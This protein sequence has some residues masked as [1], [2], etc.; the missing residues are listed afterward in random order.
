MDKIPIRRHVKVKK[1]MRVFNKDDKEYWL[2][3]ENNQLALYG[4]HRQLYDKQ[5]GRCA[6]CEQDF[7]Y[8]DRNT[9]HI[10]H[11]KPLKYDGETK[12]SNLRLIHQEC[13]LNIHRLFS[14]EEMSELVNKGID[15]ITLMKGKA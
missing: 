4:T 5:K 1:G 14:V 2:K 15:Y 10:H 8:E 6:Y 9:L 11:L 7:N 12:L 3:R 13:H